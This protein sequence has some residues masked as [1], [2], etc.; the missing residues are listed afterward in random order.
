MRLFYIVSDKFEPTDVH[1]PQHFRLDNP[2]GTTYTPDQ[3]ST[4][5]SS[6]PTGYQN[7]IV[8]ST[9]PFWGFACH[10][11]SYLV[12]A[13]YSYTKVT[14]PPPT[15]QRIG[16]I[17]VSIMVNFNNLIVQSE[18]KILKW[19]PDNS[20]NCDTTFSYTLSSSQKKNCQLTIDIYSTE[21][22]KVYETTL[23]QLC[24]GTYTF[25]WD[26]TANQTSYPP[27]S[28]APTGLYTFDIAVQGACPYDGDRMR[29]S[30][31]SVSQTSLDIE[32]DKYKFGYYFESSD[33][34]LPSKAEV[35]VY[36]P[37]IDNFKKN[38]G[39]EE[40]PTDLGKWNYAR[41]PFNAIKIGGERSFV[42]VSGWDSDVY[43]KK[44]QPKPF[45]EHNQTPK[46]PTAALFYATYRWEYGGTDI[47][48]NPVWLQVDVADDENDLLSSANEAHSQLTKKVFRSKPN[49]GQEPEYITFAEQWVDKE[50]GKTYPMLHPAIKLKADGVASILDVVFSALKNVNVF[51]FC[52]HGDG[53]AIEFRSESLTSGGE[54]TPLVALEKT[55][56]GKLEL[57]KK[58]VLDP[59]GDNYTFVPL[60]EGTSFSNLHLVVIASCRKANVNEFPI[61]KA[62]VD[63]G[64]KY[65]I[66]VGS[67]SK[68][69]AADPWDYD[70]NNPPL[71]PSEHFL[72]SNVTKTWSE[73][74]WE[75]ATKEY[76]KAKNE[77]ERRQ[78]MGQAAV[79]AAEET[80]R[81]LGWWYERFWYCVWRDGKK[82]TEYDDRKVYIYTY[83][84]DDYLGN[85]N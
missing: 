60:P 76:K 72:W 47:N 42:V 28:I 11:T 68:L 19:D 38:W 77:N 40:G 75:I 18:P 54:V 56:D 82:E 2:Q 55:R 58:F 59:Y 15:Y 63:K 21:G 36:G 53:N 23:T 44:H 25:T 45:L 80:N 7:Y 39:P 74:F 35:T 5:C 24:P 85:I 6:P 14:G 48:G 81:E 52:G 31:I 29:S 71:Y 79:T 43:N 61:V 1:E 27:N 73:H 34:S 10:N 32:E 62:L 46:P 83:G 37:A 70:T 65:G 33:G 17:E 20:N 84:Q 26:G 3:I 4:V 22:T 30:I 57:G 69:F 78:M 66:G 49:E 12:K 64:A 9:P 50:N 41:F 16:P 13:S 8:F 67:K 51:Y